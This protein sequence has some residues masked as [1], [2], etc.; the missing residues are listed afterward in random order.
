MTMDGFSPSRRHIP[1]HNETDV[2]IVGASP[3]G[4]TI[5][6]PLYTFTTPGALDFTAKT[7]TLAA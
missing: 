3:A 7:F 5:A 4:L 2:L 6:A 1:P